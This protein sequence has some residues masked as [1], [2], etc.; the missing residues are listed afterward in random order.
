[1]NFHP[2]VLAAHAQFGGD[3]IS[4]QKLYEYADLKAEVEQLRAALVLIAHT[5]VEDSHGG[6]KSLPASEYQDIARAALSA[7]GTAAIRQKG[8]SK[9]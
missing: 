5:F 4:M 6:T 1:M 9:L 7:T 2:D 3:L 8:E